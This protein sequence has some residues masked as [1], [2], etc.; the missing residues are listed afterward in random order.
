VVAL[1]VA[2]MVA[3]A[4]VAVPALLPEGGPGAA[5]PVAASALYHAAHIA[6]TL[7][8]SAPPGP[9]QYVYTKTSSVQTSLYVPGHGLAD[10]SFTEPLTREAWIGPDGSGRTIETSGD[11]T[12]PTPQDRLAFEAAGTPDLKSG[13]TSGDHTYPPGELYFVDL[14]KLP[15]DPGELKALLEERR[16]EG[17]PKG[18]WETFAIVGDLLR[19][20]WA[21]PEVRAALYEVAANLPGV[22]WVG[23]VT[24]DTGRPGVAVA[25][26]HGGIRDEL[27]FDP[28]TA[29]LLGAISVLVD[30]D[31]VGIDLDSE[32]PGT[33]VA[34]AGPA[35]EV[36]YSAVY[37]DSGVVD[38]AG[39]RP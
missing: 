28:H 20:T 1:A 16:I 13:D 12:F 5:D 33:T 21:P 34:Y 26:T 14:S 9:G 32:A 31:A 17:G 15:A 24:D 22:E 29:G 3:L 8:A 27:I 7:P 19:E 2:G 30:P 18:D 38:S 36:V 10:F 6:L 25:Y 39:Q 23:D 37:L 11:V 4:A 35:G